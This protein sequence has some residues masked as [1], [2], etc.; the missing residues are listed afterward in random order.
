MQ[1]R[2]LFVLCIE[3]KNIMR[4]I[5]LLTLFTIIFGVTQITEARTDQ[6]IKVQV[7]KQKS[8]N[9]NDLTVK[10]V[11]VVEDSRC[12][13]GVNCV[14]AGNAKIELKLKKK[15]GA[16]KTFK[17][18]TNVEKNVLKFGVYTIKI[19]ELTPTPAANVK[20]NPD[21]YVATFSI[22]KT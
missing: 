1:K 12:P 22:S 8:I 7:N 19:S 17:L 4:A 10:F 16:W 5:I 3:E 9:K 15:N 13:E 2:A 18:N 6:E 14:W 11:S 21:G 20:I